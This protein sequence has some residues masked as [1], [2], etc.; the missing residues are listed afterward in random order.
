LIGNDNSS[1]DLWFLDLQCGGSI[2]NSLYV[3]SAAHCFSNPNSDRFGVVLGEHTN[4]RD[5]DCELNVCAP[6]IQYRNIERV[7]IHPDYNYIEQLNDIALVRLKHPIEFNDYVKPICLNTNEKASNFTNEY[8]EVAGWGGT[9]AEKRL[10][11]ILQSLKL[12]IAPDNYC[13]NPIICAGNVKGQDTCTGDSGGPAM[14]VLI[15]DGQ[16]RYFLIGITSSGSP[17]CAE[18]KP[19]F[20]TEVYKYIRWILDNM[21]P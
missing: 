10:S 15:K 4:S 5:P 3:L 20:F 21:Q 19:A 16:P 12:K 1:L 14:K 7:I 13:S 8:M 2:L 11:D 6:S 9:N 17:V 18:G